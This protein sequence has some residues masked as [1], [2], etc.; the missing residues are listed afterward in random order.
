[1]ANKD[2][3]SLTQNLADGLLRL[4]GVE[5]Q[6]EVSEVEENDQKT[7]EVQ[8]STEHETGLLIGAHGAT[9]NAIQVFL[10]MALRQQ[11]GEWS[12][13]VVNVGDWKEKQEESLK[14]LAEQAAARARQ[15]GEEQRLYNLNSAQRRI[16][17]ML[18]SEEQD[19]E[20]ES[21]GEG[22]ERFLIVRAKN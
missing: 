18:L 6:V 4:M 11:T 12:R 2:L 5:A 19:I 3:V 7:L 9:L 13:V 10:G 8:I 15:T 1:M 16:I 20:T 22:E 14:A 21:M 17:H